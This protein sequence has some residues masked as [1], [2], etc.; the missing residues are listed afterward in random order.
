MEKSVHLEEE[1]SVEKAKNDTDSGDSS[2]VK[3]EKMDVNDEQSQSTAD[4]SVRTL[5]I[6]MF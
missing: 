4:K 6:S 3:Q 1:N 2:K 5:L